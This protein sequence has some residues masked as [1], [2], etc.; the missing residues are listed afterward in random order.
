MYEKRKHMLKIIKA[1]FQT[2]T[3][4]HFFFIDGEIF[5][6]PLSAY[7]WGRE[8]FI[9]LSEWNKKFAGSFL[10]FPK[11]YIVT[12][13][14]E[15]VSTSPSCCLIQWRFRPARTMK[16]KGLERISSPYGSD[17]CFQSPVLSLH[18]YTFGWNKD[19]ARIIFRVRVEPKFCS[20]ALLP[21]AQIVR[22]TSYV[23]V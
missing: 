23:C 14:L 15:T 7:S 8:N 21:H 18:F 9:P 17:Y 13:S 5:F 16:R 3:L 11:I 19:P 2:E 20:A 6:S 10:L 1:V 22:H 4:Y 12:R